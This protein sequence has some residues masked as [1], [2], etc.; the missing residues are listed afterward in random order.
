MTISNQSRLFERPKFHC[1]PIWT[2]TAVGSVLGAPLGWCIGLLGQGYIAI[3]DRDSR[4]FSLS[5]RPA[6]V[7]GSFTGGVVGTTFG[8][9]VSILSYGMTYGYRSYKTAQLSHAK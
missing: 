5:R 9:G 8:L 1:A 4:W 3:Y 6:A 2:G 7:I